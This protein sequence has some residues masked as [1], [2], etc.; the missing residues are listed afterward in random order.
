MWVPGEKTLPRC[1]DIGRISDTL[2]HVPMRLA[3]PA[4]PADTAT[5]PTT[6]A[7]RDAP[8]AGP[9]VVAIERVTK[10][11]GDS[12]YPIVDAFQLA[13][14]E[15]DIVCLL[16]PSG[17][18]KTTLLRMIAGFD[19][20]DRGAVRIR[21]REVVG[22]RAWVRPED[23]RIGF[24]FQDFALFPH[25][26][27]LQNVAFGIRGGSRSERIDRARD[28]LDLVGLTI[29][30]GR[31]PH[32]LSGGQQQRVALARALAPRP[33]VILLD[34]PFSNLDAGL[35]EATRDDVRRI[36][37][38]TRTTAVL[39]THDQEEALAFA[40]R[41]VVMRAGRLEQVGAPEDVYRLPRT[42]FVAQFLGRT[43][44]L[45]GE[46]RGAVADTQLGSVALTKSATGSVLLS[47]RP[48]DL[49]FDTREGLVVEVL[50]RRFKGHDLTFA[51]RVLEAPDDAPPVLVQTGPEC[52]IHAGERARVVPRAPAVPLEG[53][54]SADP[55]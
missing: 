2:V 25:L 52:E 1:S 36:L 11:F 14:D 26:T 54:R 27:V 9:P 39:V 49:A 43:N 42:A 15:G 4:S 16:G 53:S 3:E 41:L 55:G 33:E 28:V 44:L 45:R 7:N 18:G 30:Q 10:R 23:R 29:F 20:P 22:D 21:G 47:L 35:R 46:G 31:H 34:E 8:G 24:V 17:C 19:R 38:D 13:V 6:R 37:A 51:C 48:E 40:D 32:Q 12:P 5:A 50:E